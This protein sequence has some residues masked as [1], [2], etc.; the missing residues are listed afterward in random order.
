MEVGGI[1]FPMARAGAAFDVAIGLGSN[2]GQKAANIARAIE[3]LVEGD[4]VRLVAVSRLYRSEP[5][6]VL[7]QD[8]FVNAAVTVA[9][10][11]APDRLLARCQS[12][13]AAMGRVREKRWG[14]RVIDV[15]I[16]TYRDLAM[17]TASLT[18]PHPLI[19]ERA[20]VLLPLK[21]VAPDT[22]I[23]GRG[24]DELIGAIDI[25]ECVPIA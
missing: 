19:A 13:E 4:E 7:E 18:I 12:V 24:I 15:D 5:W 6:G 22:K 9:T 8:W 1:S 14:P 25:S 2:I 21:D 17:R 10:R 3:L 23:G 11:L 20:F 16:L